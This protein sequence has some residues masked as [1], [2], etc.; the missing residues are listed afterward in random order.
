MKT[1]IQKTLNILQKQKN[2]EY[3]KEFGR[4]KKFWDIFKLTHQYH[5]K[6]EKKQAQIPVNTFKKI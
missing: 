6:W 2:L 1:N 5:A 4:L 3:K